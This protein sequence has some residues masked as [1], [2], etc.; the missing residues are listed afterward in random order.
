MIGRR[1]AVGLAMLVVLVWGCRAE[2]K[3]WRRPNYD[4][5]SLA[6]MS[7]LVVRATLELRR[8]QG[9]GDWWQARIIKLYKGKAPAGR[10]VWLR[11]K[12]LRGYMRRG[13]DAE[14]N[15]TREPLR[16]GHRVILFLKRFQSPKDKRL[17]TYAPQWS[18]VKLVWD[19]KVFGLERRT[20]DLGSLERFEKQLRGSIRAAKSIGEALST[21]KGKDAVWLLGLLARRAKVKLDSLSGRDHIAELVCKWLFKNAE[22]ENINKALALL[23]KDEHLLRRYRCVWILKGR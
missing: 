18:G 12:A 8:F 9:V 1:V 10:I 15:V 11:E 13:H 23:E 5:D 22:Q 7:D 2:A 16:S 4:L 17:V 14:G 21:T 20:E 19:D 3:G 6:Y